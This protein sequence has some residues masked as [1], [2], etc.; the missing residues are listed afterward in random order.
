[1]FSTMSNTIGIRLL[2]LF[3]MV[4][5]LSMSCK[6]DEV[7]DDG[8]VTLHYDGD[9]DNAPALTTSTFESAARFLSSEMANYYNDELT[10]V[11]FYFD[12]LPDNCE[13]II[14]AT[15][16][17]NRPSDT[18]LYASG[19]IIG[20]IRSGWNTH[21]LTT[22]LVLDGTDIWVGIRYSQDGNA[23]TLGCDT[24][25]ANPNGEWLYD[26]LDGEWLPLR[27]RTNGAIN[28]NW[29]IRA[30]IELIE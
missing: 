29:N 11:E 19:N 7:I 5:M 2:V 13:V 18:P 15:G 23:R 6:D 30:V 12:E 27:T 3:L 16:A 25:P 17:Y 21:T 24:G 1:M 9:N 14:R 28:I 22:P 10:Q 26:A 20:N 8:T 4:A